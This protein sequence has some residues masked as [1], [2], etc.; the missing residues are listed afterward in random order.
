MRLMWFTAVSLLAKQQS[1]LSKKDTSALAALNSMYSEALAE[2]DLLLLDCE[3]SMHSIK[4][5]VKVSEMHVAGY[6][7]ETAAT[8]AD[9]AEAQSTLDESKVTSM[10]LSGEAQRRTEECRQ[11]NR[12][13]MEQRGILKEDLASAKKVAA[14]FECTGTALLLSCDHRGEVFLTVGGLDSLR[15][16]ARAAAGRALGAARA[17]NKTV[18][19]AETYPTGAQS[20]CRVHAAA[21]CPVLEDAMAQM[22]GEV[23]D[24]LS[25]LEDEIS[26][27]ESNCAQLEKEAKNQELEWVATGDKSNV[28]MAQATGRLNE[29]DERDRLSA[30]EHRTLKKQAKEIAKHCRESKQAVEENL[31]GIRTMRMELAQLNDE[32]DDIQDCVV[33]DW[34]KQP[35]SAQCGGGE[36]I[37]QRYKLADAHGGA[38]CPPL[39]MQRSCNMQECPVDC[40]LDDW[41]EWSAC[42]KDC[43]GG[44]R[45]RVRSVRVTSEH[46]GAPCPAQQE[47][48]VCNIGPCDMSCQYSDWT[49][50]SSC[51]ARCGGGFKVRTRQVVSDEIGSDVPC[52]GPHDPERLQPE[53]CNSEECPAELKCA[54]ALDIVVLMDGSGSVLPDDFTAQKSAVEALLGRFEFGE[55]FANVG[56]AVFGGDVAEVTALTGDQSAA[57]AAVGGATQSSAATNL[58]GALEFADH[59]IAAKGRQ[60]AQSVIIV[61]LDGPPADRR[62]AKELTERLSEHTRILVAPIGAVDLDEMVD[63]ASFPAK[64]NVL[65][66]KDFPGLA[67][68]AE[69][70]RFIATLCPVA[71]AEAS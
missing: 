54:S 3:E 71:E 13:A 31:C 68:E 29:V 51:S 17:S 46:G 45:Q 64:L 4:E 19:V 5:Q 52:A 49:A 43:G 20:K 11:S 44:V 37:L 42:S 67:E 58:A 30:Q 53:V 48:E 38:D 62:A 35:C 69:L 6:S 55:T 22:V 66:V 32:S 7:A 27:R 9:L 12:A 36:M 25:A 40:E 18:P 61:L 34:E 56:V 16:A 47:E 21:T 14:N 50:F 63:F 24:A 60:Q 8:R 15:G 23:Q 39:M 41:A 70:T 1:F 10:S 57:I 2:L 65:G 28:E 26:K 33:S 59:M